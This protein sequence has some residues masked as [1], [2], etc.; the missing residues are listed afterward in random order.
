MMAAIADEIIVIEMTVAANR[1]VEK[2]KKKMFVFPFLLL[3]AR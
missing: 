2:K 1:R 3:L